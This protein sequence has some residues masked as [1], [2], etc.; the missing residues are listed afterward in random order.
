M[1]QASYIYLPLS[2]RVWLFILITLLATTLLYFVLFTN[3]SEEHVLE[4]LSRAFLDI[5]NIVTSHGLPKVV[6]RNP[7]R[8][9]IISW[10]LLSLLLNTAYSTKY[11]SLLTQPKYTK[12]VDNIEDFLEEGKI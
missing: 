1:T 4:D 11:T 7:I 10:I 3:V 12:A 8:I 5:I 6:K 9:L 2:P